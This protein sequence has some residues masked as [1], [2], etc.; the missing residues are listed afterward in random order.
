VGFVRSNKLGGGAVGKFPEDGGAFVFHE[1]HDGGSEFLPA[2]LGNSR[3]TAIWVL[4]QVFHE[5]ERVRTGRI[6]G[7]A[8]AVK[9]WREHFGQDNGNSTVG[10]VLIV[11]FTKPLEKG[12]DPVGSRPEDN[13]KFVFPAKGVRHTY[14]I[15]P[16]QCGYTARNA[17][18]CLV[19]IVRE[20][21]TVRNCIVEGG[22]EEVE[23]EEQRRVAER[24][25]EFDL[26]QKENAKKM[27]A[28]RA[29]VEAYV[30]GLKGAPQSH[31]F[32]IEGCAYEL[33]VFP[34]SYESG[35]VGS[36]TYKVVTDEVR[37][38]GPWLP[39]SGIRVGV[40]Y[41]TK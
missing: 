15:D 1:L 10:Q 18:W 17:H 8:E 7:D 29:A 35:R 20:G 40:E 34:G 27:A 36:A 6:V 28:R 22:P 4:V 12:K 31:R 25:A 9:A 30:H 2:M 13:G 26:A 32:N 11:G 41:T 37:V 3:E 24:R 33:I 23:A 39:T 14:I 16:E 19:R 5:G 21:K 38:T